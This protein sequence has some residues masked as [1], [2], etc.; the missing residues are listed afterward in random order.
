VFLK[1]LPDAQTGKH[2]IVLNLTGLTQA[3]ASSRRGVKWP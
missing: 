1:Q 2:V 3:L